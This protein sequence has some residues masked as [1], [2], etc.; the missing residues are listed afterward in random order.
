MLKRKVFEKLF[1]PFNKSSNQICVIGR[2]KKLTLPIFYLTKQ[3]LKLS[4]IIIT[5]AEV[6]KTQKMLWEIGI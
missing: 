3:N 2:V 5:P 4:G 1:L 6:K